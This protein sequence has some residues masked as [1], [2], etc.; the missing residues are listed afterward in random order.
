MGDRIEAGTLL[1]AAA[2][3]G[4]SIELKN[5]IPEYITSVLYKLEECGATV[6]ITKSAVYLKAPKRLGP[7]QIKT[8]PYPR[9]PN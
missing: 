3:T 5:V 9:L 8:M 2:I 6:D 4:G 1:L 7:T